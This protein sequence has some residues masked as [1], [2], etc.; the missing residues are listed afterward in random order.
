MNYNG[1]LVC[2]YADFFEGSSYAVYECGFLVFAFSSPRFNNHYWHV[3]L[4]PPTLC[5]LSFTLAVQCILKRFVLLCL[6][7]DICRELKVDT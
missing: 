2:G 1:D 4:S 3:V 6:W 7:G 5:C